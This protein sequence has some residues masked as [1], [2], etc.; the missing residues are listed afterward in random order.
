MPFTVRAWTHTAS[1]NITGE[2]TVYGQAG[3]SNRLPYEQL[4][5]RAK[6]THARSTCDNF[7]L[8]N[9]IHPRNYVN[10][11]DTVSLLPTA[12][13]GPTMIYKGEDTCQ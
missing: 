12:Q 10:I 11:V 3:D 9:K 13:H 8:L 1:Q 6:E 5:H 2:E 7:A 4:Y